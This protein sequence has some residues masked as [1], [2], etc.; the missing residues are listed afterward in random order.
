MMLNS[1]LTFPRRAMKNEIKKN[2]ESINKI[3]PEQETSRRIYSEV[4][5]SFSVDIF[6]FVILSFHFYRFA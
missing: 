1:P 5:E 3:L 6:V 2:T 4:N